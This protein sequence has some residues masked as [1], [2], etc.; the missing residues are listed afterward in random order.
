[1]CTS[2]DLLTNHHVQVHTTTS[3][4]PEISVGITVLD[5]NNW[6]ITITQEEWNCY[7]IDLLMKPSIG[8][9][10]LQLIRW[11]SLSY[12]FRSFKAKTYSNNQ[13][14]PS[15]IYT[16]NWYKQISAESWSSRIKYSFC[17]WMMLY[18][19]MT[20]ASKWLPSIL[21][22]GC[23]TFKELYFD[24]RSSGIELSSSEEL[25]EYDVLWLILLLMPPLYSTL[26]SL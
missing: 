20:A 21:S 2:P 6:F 15:F 17:F 4:K 14:F 18:L 22:T 16:A 9:P 13:F 11:P 10:T 25:D 5:K 1:M 12:S 7:H 8:F 23:P 3:Q 19:T 26:L 24:G